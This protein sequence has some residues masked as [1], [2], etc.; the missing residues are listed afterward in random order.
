M[1]VDAL[2]QFV[3]ED[4]GVA[5]LRMQFRHV[6]RDEREVATLLDSLSARERIV[7]EMRFGF[8][9]R[10]P[11]TQAATGRRLGLKRT[12]VRRIEEYALSKLRHA[13]GVADLAAA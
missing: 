4:G 12:E 1:A 7:L 8:N 11:A 2:A 6:V 13:P 9:G 3:D 10:E 5:G